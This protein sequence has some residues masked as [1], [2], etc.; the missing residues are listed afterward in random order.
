MRGFQAALVVRGADEVGGV[1]PF[2]AVVVLVVVEDREGE[3]EAGGLGK[4]RKG[5]HDGEERG[6]LVRGVGWGGA[7]E[8]KRE[9]E[10]DERDERDREIEREGERER[11]IGR[12]RQT[13]R[14][15]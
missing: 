14:E 12:D 7:Y 9:R 3:G 13:D 15:R 6:R 11:E 8:R 5:W 4:E 10:R 2:V 1:I